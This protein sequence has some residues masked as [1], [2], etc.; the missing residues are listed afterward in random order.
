M[1]IL[2]ALLIGFVVVLVGVGAQALPIN[3]LKCSAVNALGT[4][5]FIY[6]KNANQIESYI[7]GSKSPQVYT[8]P[9]Y[10][11]TTIGSNKEATISSV[12]MNAPHESVMGQRVLYH[13]YF[14]SVA[15]P[16]KKSHLKGVLYRTAGLAIPVSHVPV[17]QVS[18]EILVPK[19]N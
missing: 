8:S 12:S 18:C 1:K 15:V 14:T 9:Y 3:E 10:V 11:A 13:M 2:N 4:A 5:S 16:G 17:A 7:N 19:P 6:D